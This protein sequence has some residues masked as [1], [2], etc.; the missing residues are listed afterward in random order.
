MKDQERVHNDI[1]ARLA[2]RKDALVDYVEA[3]NSG[4]VSQHDQNQL[5]KNSQDYKNKRKRID[6]IEREM[7]A[8]Q[9]ILKN[10]KA[11]SSGTTEDA[12]KKKYAAY[13]VELKSLQK[14]LE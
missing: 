14:Y 4:G 10:G 12:L 5:M 6:D 3:N 9:R 2:E 13:Q 1:R 8:I 11:E 7:A